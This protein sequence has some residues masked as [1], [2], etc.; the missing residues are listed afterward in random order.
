MQTAYITHP[1][2]L[3]HNMGYDHPESPERLRAIENQLIASGI[4]PLLQ[5]HEAPRVTHEQLVRVHSESY[6]HAIE[7]VAPQH[8]MISLDAD[9]LMNPFTLEAAYRAAGALVLA[10]DLVMTEK[11]ENAFC[12]IR[13]PGH[14]ATHSQAMGFCFFNNVAVGAAHAMTQYALKRVAIA[15]FD[16]HHGN[17]TEDI[18]K[19]DPRV[20]LC[21]TFQHPF[22]P[23]CGAD[24]SSNH[25]INVPL[26]AHTDGREFRSAISQH[27]LPALESFQ[28]EMI[29]ISAGFDAH[30]EDDMA[31]LNLTESDYTWVTGQIKAIAGKYAQKR[32]VSALEGGYA[33]HAL[34]RS[35]TAH[36]KVL[37]GL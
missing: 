4:F 12:N 2:C 27:W 17:G 3:K 16:V 10:T 15:D 34:G 13:P 11:V 18:F 33:L 29:F 7:A 28:P 9:T 19:H 26:T 14:H 37:G 31:R 23:Y 20:M 36:I 32:I 8:G 25:I 21:S 24:S 35:A 6:L 5:Q 1:T 30:R 22:Y